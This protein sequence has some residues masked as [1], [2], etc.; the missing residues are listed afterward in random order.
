L[1]NDPLQEIVQ[2]HKQE[3]LVR[4]NGLPIGLGEDREVTGALAEGP[5]QSIVGGPYS[6]RSSGSLTSMAFLQ[7]ARTAGLAARVC[8]RGSVNTRQ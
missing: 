1:I 3:I 7:A 2:P 8:R 6:T 5:A 4:L